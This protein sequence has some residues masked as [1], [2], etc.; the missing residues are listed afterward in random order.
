MWQMLASWAM[1]S[2]VVQRTEAWLGRWASVFRGSWLAAAI[3]VSWQEAPPAYQSSGVRRL[4]GRLTAGALH[5]R[6]PTAWLESSWLLGRWPQWLLSDLVWLWENSLLCHIWLGFGRWVMDDHWSSAEE[7]R[8]PAPPL[9]RWQIYSL[10]LVGLAVVVWQWPAHGPLAV[11]LLLFGVSLL[12]LWAEPAGTVYVVAFVLPFLPVLSTTYL[13]VWG[14]LVSW[15]KGRW[16]PRSSLLLLLAAVF[17]LVLLFAAWHS[18]DVGHSLRYLR[19]YFAGLALLLLI[20][21][22]LSTPQ[23]LRQLLAAALC[24]AALT[25]IWGT[26]QYVLR[27]ATDISW[28]D[29]RVS[30]ITTRVIGPFDNPNMFA[31]YLVALLPFPL[32]M[33]I[34]AQTRLPVRLANAALAGLL[35]LVLLFTFSRGAWLALLAAGFVLAIYLQPRL[36]WALPPLLIIAPWVLP[37]VVWQRLASIVNLEDTSNMVRLHVWDSSLSMWLH[38]SWLGIGLGIVPFAAVYPMFQYGIVPALHAHN[39]FLQVAVEG[40]TVALVAFL[41]LCL[42]LWRAAI[43]RWQLQPTMA[44]ATAAA[45]AGQLA[46]GLFDYN[47]YDLR[48]LLAFWLLGGLVIVAYRQR[49]GEKVQS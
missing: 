36:F 35:G 37:E 47:W 15:I 48:L 44:I 12:L 39:L 2:L 20:D 46:Y 40:G 34:H 24:A 16:Q 31:G 18:I 30:A 19:Y 49:I 23:Q 17:C 4:A 21:N 3:S 26:A 33:V 45:L 25:A 7:S 32:A 38:N 5:W 11:K 22:Y 10:V 8:A 43:T 28:V 27:F 13:I 29:I 6:I 41:L 9:W 42:G 1:G 14:L